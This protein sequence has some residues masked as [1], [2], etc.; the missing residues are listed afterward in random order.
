M[1]YVILLSCYVFFFK[2]SLCLI[3]VL[4]SNSF[5]RF[6]PLFLLYA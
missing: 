4:I 3:C 2:K 6:V 1:D 5:L